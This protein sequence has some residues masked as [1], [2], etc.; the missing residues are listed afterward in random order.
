VGAAAGVLT[1]PARSSR[2]LLWLGGGA[3]AV[4]AAGIVVILVI[5]LGGGSDD[6]TDTDAAGA[7]GGAGATTAQSTEPPPPP[8]PALPD[9]AYAVDTTV[10][11]EH[12]VWD[13]AG[14]TTS[15]TWTIDLACEEAPC[16]GT[17]T[18][19]NGS[20]TAD[21]DGTTMHVAGSLQLV[22]DCYSD[23]TG[24][25]VPGS[26]LTAHV[27]FSGDFTASEAVDGERPTLS[28]PLQ[29]NWSTVST[30]LE[31]RSE[32]AGTSTRQANLTPA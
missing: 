14:N 24:E 11:V 12:P 7:T 31:C 25:L 26:T 2:K 27:D 28:G 30:T 17:L 3:A 21:F 22:F 9:G 8:P 16:S 19:Q 18:V 13:P 15:E 10:S 1:Q 29:L 20:G 6:P 32:E 4:V 23:D 5:V